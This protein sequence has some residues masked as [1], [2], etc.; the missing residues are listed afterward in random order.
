MPVYEYLCEQCGATF[1]LTE[2]VK[3]H[4]TGQAKCPKCGSEKTAHVPTP[5]YAKTSKKS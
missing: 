3:E 5:F 1:S 4:E 2:H